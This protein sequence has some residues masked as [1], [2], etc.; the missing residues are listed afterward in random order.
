MRLI[1]AYLLA[2]YSASEE[3][4]GNHPG[5]VLLDEP[6]QHSMGVTS[7]NA[8]LTNISKQRNIQSIVAASFDESDE[9]FDESVHGVNHHLIECGYKLLKPVSQM[10]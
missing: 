7:V 2:L 5:L 8:L 3:L 9:V 1:W 6:G 10:P 4:G